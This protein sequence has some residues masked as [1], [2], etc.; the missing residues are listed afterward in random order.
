MLSF[1]SA[2]LTWNTGAGARLAAEDLENEWEEL[3]SIAQRANDKRK[4]NSPRTK[5]P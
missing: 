2:R 5:G 3:R 1:V 4:S